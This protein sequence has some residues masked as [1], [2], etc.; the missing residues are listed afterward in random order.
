MTYPKIL[1]RLFPSLFPAPSIDGVLSNFTK[2]MTKLSELQ[3]DKKTEVARI[4]E[5]SRQLEQQKGAA[6][7][8]LARASNVEAKLRDLLD[9]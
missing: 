6:S 4:N 9:G 7:V 3:E 2:T 8:E 1:S 5:Q